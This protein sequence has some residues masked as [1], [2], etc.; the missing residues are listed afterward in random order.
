MAGGRGFWGTVVVGHS[1][2]LKNL[3]TPMAKNK[4]G[5]LCSNEYRLWL[6]K[7]QYFNTKVCS[8]NVLVSC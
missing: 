1:V 2:Y 6:L 3:E 4:I 5:F 7:L 8:S